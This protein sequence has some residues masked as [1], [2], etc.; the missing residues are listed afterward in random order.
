MIQARSVPAGLSVLLPVP[1]HKTLRLAVPGGSA[2]GLFSA[3][4]QI[5]DALL[6]CPEPCSAADMWRLQI[7]PPHLR[8]R[9]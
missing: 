1:G 9:P 4:G 7:G 5:A 6:P 2:P 3:S 8:N